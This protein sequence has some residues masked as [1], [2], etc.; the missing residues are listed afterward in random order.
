MRY[1]VR[2]MQRDII[3]FSHGNG[4]PAAS[5]RK[6]L[7][8][9]GRNFEIG[10]INAIGHNPGYPVSDNWPHLAG[11][12]ADYLRGHYDRPVI[13]VGHSLGGFLT[14]L[15]AAQH[16]ELF[17][18]IVLLDAPL[19]GP[20]VSRVLLLSK[21][22]GLIDRLSPAGRTRT[23]RSEWASREEAIAHFRQRKPFRRFDAEC[24]RDYVTAGTVPSA[25]GVR[26]AFA[27]E[28][29]SAIYRTTPHNFAEWR[30]KLRVPAGFLSGRESEE[31]RR[32][33]LTF[34]RRHFHFNYMALPG[35]HLF[36]LEHP[37]ETAQAVR[38]M[39]ARLLPGL[40][41]AAPQA[42]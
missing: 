26:L 9:L 42:G 18:A 36:P 5:Y 3:H 37:H 20:F 16:P 25:N 11:E 24:L 19:I 21:H 23:R 32:V 29:E 15:A 30:G 7:E 38:E 1:D 41:V 35:T 10:S 39:I 34:M 13:G 28:V 17:S 14:F 40:P 6:L 8:D 12:L 4:F 33:G 27:P 22:L 31:V 2:P